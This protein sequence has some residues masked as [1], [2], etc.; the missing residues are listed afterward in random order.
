MLRQPADPNVR[1]FKPEPAYR[2]TLVARDLVPLYLRGI[3]IN[4][5]L[6]LAGVILAGLLT[7]N[8]FAWQ[9][10]IAAAGAAY[11]SYTFLAVG[12]HAS[13][14]WTF[15]GQVLAAFSVILAAAAGLALIV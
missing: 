14:R 15:W 2:P 12:Y 3:Q 8:P 13:A 9:P 10:A 7:R 1:G 11:L 6:Y 5:A 4:A